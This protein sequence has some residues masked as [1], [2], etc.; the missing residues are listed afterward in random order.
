MS[1]IAVAISLIA[2]LI[3]HFVWVGFRL[4]PNPVWVDSAELSEQAGGGN[5]RLYFQ[6]Q[7][8]FLGFSYALAVAFSVFAL[9]RI[10]TDRKKGILGTFGGVSLSAGLYAFG[11]FLVGCCGS[12]MIIVYAGLFGSSFLGFTKPLIFLLTTL[13]LALGYW[14]MTRKKKGQCGAVS[15]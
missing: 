8:Y 9:S 2:V 10:K 13:S 6:D 4:T 5:Y 7:D 11:C 14:R 1:K 15:E 12:P 3:I